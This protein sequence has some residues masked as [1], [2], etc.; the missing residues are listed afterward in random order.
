MVQFHSFDVTIHISQHH[1][2]KL[3]FIYVQKYIMGKEQSVQ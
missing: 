2:L 3:S 1:L